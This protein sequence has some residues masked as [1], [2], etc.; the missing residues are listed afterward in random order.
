MILC[1][2]RF[3]PDAGPMGKR[4]KVINDFKSFEGIRIIRRTDIGN[5]IQRHRGIVMEK[6]RNFQP[7]IGLYLCPQIQTHGILLRRQHSL[8]KAIDQ[9][10]EKSMH[11][12]DMLLNRG[13]SKDRLHNFQSYFTKYFSF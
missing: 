9:R 5:M 3:N 10:F 7:M 12:S 13:I 1:H 2:A 8:R 11:K 6:L 4:E